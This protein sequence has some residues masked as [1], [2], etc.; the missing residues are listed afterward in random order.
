MKVYKFV[1]LAVRLPRHTHSTAHLESLSNPLTGRPCAAS[2]EGGVRHHLIPPLL[3]LLGAHVHVC[4]FY[5]Q[6]H[7]TGSPVLCTESKEMSRNTQR[8]N[9]LP[10]AERGVGGGHDRR[11]PALAPG[12]T[13]PMFTQHPRRSVIQ[14]PSASR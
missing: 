2:A 13:C 8:L 14:L 1:P 5:M 12:I 11:Q 6:I 3:L 4:T 9:M 10:E 7:A